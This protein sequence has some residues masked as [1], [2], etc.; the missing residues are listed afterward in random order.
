MPWYNFQFTGTSAAAEDSATATIA[1]T[2]T[3]AIA[4]SQSIRLTDIVLSATATESHQLSIWVNGKKQSSNLYSAQ[5]NP[6]SQGRFSI[7]GQGILIGSGA[8]LQMRGAQLVTGGGA[9][10]ITATLEFVAA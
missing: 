5:L 7:R 1:E 4:L 3:T 2:G 9:E 10:N 8:T 6:A